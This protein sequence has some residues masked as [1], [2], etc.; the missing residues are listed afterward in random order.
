M[1]SEWKISIFNTTTMV[2]NNGYSIKKV[3]LEGIFPTNT[4]YGVGGRPEN[5]TILWVGCIAIPPH[6]I[7]YGG[8]SAGGWSK[9]FGNSEGGWS[10]KSG[11]DTFPT[12]FF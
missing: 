1:N 2:V 6:M 4:Y 5:L 9:K 8:N 10:E 11:A 7:V 12:N 3:I